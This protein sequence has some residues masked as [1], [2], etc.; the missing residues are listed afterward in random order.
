MLLLI[1]GQVRPVL[2]REK[3]TWKYEYFVQKVLQMKYTLKSLVKHINGNTDTT[4][5]P[6]GDVCGNC[7]IAYHG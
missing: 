2:F 6:Y 1:S 4:K 7:N 3:F 5:N